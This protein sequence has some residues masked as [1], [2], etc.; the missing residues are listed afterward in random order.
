MGPGNFRDVNQ[1]RRCDV[2]QEPRT[3]TFDIQMFLSFVQAW[4]LWPAGSTSAAA[5]AAAALTPRAP[6]RAVALSR[7]PPARP[8]GTTRSR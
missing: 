5:A 3:G 4:T 6:A 2:Q 7:A 1:N 8:T